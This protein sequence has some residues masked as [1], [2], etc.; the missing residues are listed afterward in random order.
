[1]IRECFRTKTGIQFHRDSFK[2]I[3]LDVNTIFPRVL[4]R[5]HA[6]KASP[7]DVTDAKHTT[8]AAEATDSTQTSLTA[9]SAFKT[10]EEEELADAL[11]KIHDELEGYSAWWILE[12]LPLRYSKQDRGNASWGTY[13]AYVPSRDPLCYAGR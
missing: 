10:E 6:L 2:E 5:P 4:T 11:S 3:G 13:W 9:A 1:M 12:I 8:H 7:C